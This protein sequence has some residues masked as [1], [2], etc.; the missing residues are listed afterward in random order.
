[1]KLCSGVEVVDPEV[2]AA[3]TTNRLETNAC[4]CSRHGPTSG[5]FRLRQ[6]ADRSADLSERS[7]G[8]LANAI[9]EA[10]CG[11]GSHEIDGEYT[12]VALDTPW[13]RHRVGRSDD[14][15]NHD[16]AA[17]CSMK[18]SRRN[19]ENSA[20]ALLVEISEMNRALLGHSIPSNAAS[21]AVS[22]CS[23]SA[24]SLGASDFRHAAA[25]SACA[26]N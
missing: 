15:G 21:I 4:R 26:Q 8:R 13:K 14:L 6:L 5:S 9:E 22:R 12:V 1:M 17:C 18:S 23:S 24:W 3:I 10:I 19:D 2:Y 11:E 20:A 16:H 7:W 25:S